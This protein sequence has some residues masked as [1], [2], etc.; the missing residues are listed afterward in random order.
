MR[1]T[2]RSLLYCFLS[3][4][5]LASACS[6]ALAEGSQTVTTTCPCTVTLQVGAHGR[7]TVEGVDYTGSGSF[8]KDCG[9]V[10]SYAFSPNLLYALDKVLYNGAEVTDQL[11][12]GGVYTAPPLTGNASL[13][14]SFRLLDIGGDTLYKVRFDANGHGIAPAPQS[15]ISGNRAFPPKRPKARGWTFGGWFR[16]RECRSAFDF[17]APITRDITLYAK[18]T[19]D[20]SG[21][22]DEAAPPIPQTGDDSRSA[23]YSAVALICLGIMGAA[24]G[25]LYGRK[26]KQ[27]KYE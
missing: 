13:S 2:S 14:V 23:L 19:A 6:A 4:L 27:G 7:V 10:V 22:S 11:L 17:S 25:A 15:V 24:G 26:R 5:L 3:L 9:A 8:Q 20:G 12:S 16:D 21:D 1:R 18:W